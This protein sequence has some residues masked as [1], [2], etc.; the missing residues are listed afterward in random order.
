MTGDSFAEH[1]ELIGEFTLPPWDIRSSGWCRSKMDPPCGVCGRDGYFNVPEGPPKLVYSGPVQRFSVADTFERFGKA[2]KHADV[3]KS[4]VGS[5]QM[6]VSD[7]MKNLL[8]GETD[9]SFSPVTL[10]D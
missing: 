5:P 4:Y 6:L 3:R 9:V 1:H 8:A 2:R 7:E 10:I